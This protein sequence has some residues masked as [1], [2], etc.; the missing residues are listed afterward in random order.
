MCLCQR[1]RAEQVLCVSHRM[2][3][4]AADSL[5]WAKHCASALFEAVSRTLHLDQIKLNVRQT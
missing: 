3:S 2:I 5:S 4:R 1:A